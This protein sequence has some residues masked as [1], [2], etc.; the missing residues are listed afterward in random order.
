[1]HVGA[2]CTM[3]VPGRT[4]TGSKEAAFPCAIHHASF[5][6]TRYN[7]IVSP[8]SCQTG[9]PL[10]LY[11]PPTASDKQITPPFPPITSIH[12]YCSLPAPSS[13][14]SSGSLLLHRL[15]AAGSTPP[16]SLLALLRQLPILRQQTLLVMIT[17]TD[18]SWWS[19]AADLV[20]ERAERVVLET[21]FFAGFLVETYWVCHSCCTPSTCRRSPRI[22]AAGA[23]GSRGCVFGVRG[24]SA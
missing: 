6:H 4:R 23:R 20:Q 19:R 9:Q 18:G 1:M 3:H 14:P 5:S 17:T 15:P 2:S 11:G 21:A 16:A 7:L 12:P 8:R 10:L 13:P 22:R 24:R